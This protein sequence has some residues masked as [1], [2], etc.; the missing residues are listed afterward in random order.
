MASETTTQASFPQDIPEEDEC[1]ENIAPGVAAEAGTSKPKVQAED[2]MCYSS[3]QLSEQNG[4]LS[5]T[6]TFSTP[7]PTNAIGGSKSK[8]RLSGFQ[9]ALTPILKYLNIGNSR[10][11]P[12]ALKHGFPPSNQ[13]SSG[14]SPRHPGS[15]FSTHSGRAGGGTSAAVCLLDYEFLPEITLLDFTCDS[16]MQ[17]TTNDSVLPGSAPATPK[18]CKAVTCAEENDADPPEFPKALVKTT[19]TDPDVRIDAPSWNKSSPVSSKILERYLPD[20]TLLDVS[21]DYALSPLDPISSMDITQNSSPLDHSKTNRALSE[22]GEDI[23]EEPDRSDTIQNEETSSTSIHSVK[24]VRENV[25]KTSL[26]GTRD[27]TMGSVLENS[28]SSLEPGGQTMEMPQASADNTLDTKPVNVTN[29]IN[30]SS[31]M[32]TQCAHFS[33][34]AQECKVTSNRVDSEHESEPIETPDTVEK[35]EELLSNCDTESTN[36]VPQE[37]LKTDVSGNGTFTVVQPSNLSASSD[38]NSTASIS[39]PENKTLPAS[40]VN[41]PKVESDATDQAQSVATEASCV[42]NQS[43]SAVKE[44][45]LCEVQNTTFDKFSLE[46]SSGSTTFG[47]SVTASLRP[48]NNTFDCKPPSQQNATITLS[49]TSSSDSQHNTLDK[50]SSP[51]VCHLTTSLKDDSAEVHPPELPKQNETADAAESNGKKVESP[52][53]TVEANPLLQSLTGGGGNESNDHSQS[54]Q[55]LTE[56]LSDS[57][58]HQSINTENNKANPFSLDETLDLRAESLITSTPMTNCKMFNLDSE[59]E[60]GKIL[61]VQKKLYGDG[62]SKPADQPPSNIVCDR[63]TF[64]TQPAAKSIWPPSKIA[65]QLAKFKPASVPLKRLEPVTSGLPL[66]RQKAEAVRNSAPPEEPQMTTGIPNS[67]NLR[68]TTAVLASKLPSSG[69]QRPQ[70]SGIPSVFQKAAPGLRPPSA[71]INTEACSTSDKPCGPTAANVV[72]KNP[73]GRKYPFTRGEAFSVSKRKKLGA[74]VPTSTGDALTSCD[75]T[76][77]A[78]AMKQPAT[79]HRALQAKPQGHGCAKCSLLEEQLK[80]KSEEIQRLKEELLKYSKE[81]GC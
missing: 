36:R 41:S 9:S 79:S 62:P 50:P 57:S 31:D 4:L 22:V 48:Q 49:E 2:G 78:R 80:E 19:S 14:V 32:S 1:R 72:P 39:C 46:K 67:Y 51:K 64:L 76:N 10:P 11:P 42:E 44:I 55:L 54:G 33:T 30:S 74:A 25:L 27:I 13:K 69:L 3:T 38:F 66:K 5:N 58:S 17:L 47:E 40:T 43:C 61:T 28:K 45:T 7:D 16:T 8:S 60:A 6:S 26:E 35:N 52:N 77:K 75:V 18:L 29:D 24:C 37:D 15:D 56:S 63:K 21:S 73:Q 12:D 34:S 59:R 68:S 81:E 20:I 53:G 71:R 23:V 70:L 65:S